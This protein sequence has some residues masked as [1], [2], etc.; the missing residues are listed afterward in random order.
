MMAKKKVKRVYELEVITTSRGIATVVATSEQEAREKC[1]RW[2][3]EDVYA[4][5]EID[6]EDKALISIEDI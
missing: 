3:F 1:R 2:D 6:I 5:E 4:E